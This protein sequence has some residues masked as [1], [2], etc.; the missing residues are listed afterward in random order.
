MCQHFKGVIPTWN[1]ETNSAQVLPFPA[2]SWMNTMMR[3]FYWSAAMSQQASPQPKLDDLL[4]GYL[5]RQAGAHASGLATFDA[6][7][8]IPYEAGP[9]QPI[10]P[11]PAWDEALTALTTEPTEKLAPPPHWPQLVANHEPVVA[12][13]WSTG[14]FPQLVRSFYTLLHQANLTELRPNGGRP[15]SAPALEDWARGV[16][17][18]KKFP[19]ALLAL[20]ALRLA[21]QFEQA[22]SVLKTAAKNVPTA[23]RGAW[24]NEAAALAWHKGDA[25]AA[26][27][28]WD[29]A[30]PSLPVRFNR[31]MA[32]LFCGD[33]KTA[34]AILQDVVNEIPESSAW[35][36]LARL[37]LTLA[38]R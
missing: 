16:A 8:V 33:S 22:D 3:V 32:A 9:V 5:N 37:Y 10:D 6:A 4:A 28:L 7:E 2:L 27:Q 14:N 12:L 38:N 11:Q 13:A 34:A 18:K 24:D 15:T 35:H 17:A 21:K 25:E 23:W 29:A 20:G 1:D 30:D 26:R 36:H 19:E 31:G